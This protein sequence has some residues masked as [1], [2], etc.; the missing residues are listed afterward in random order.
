MGS[1]SL[2]GLFS[3]HP[4]VSATN[5][6]QGAGALDLPADRMMQLGLARERPDQRVGLTG[7]QTSEVRHSQM[8]L[9][10]RLAV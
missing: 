4:W 6:S 3:T 2:S 8:V 7:L 5:P 10:P 9:T 1:I